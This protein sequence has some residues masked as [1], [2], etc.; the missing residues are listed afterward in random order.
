MQ[1]PVLF[2]TIKIDN[3]KINYLDYHQKR[4]T[5]SR[6]ALFQSTDILDLSSIIVA[7]KMGIWRCRIYYAKSFISVE[8]IPYTPKKIQRLKI[9]PSSLT[10]D[11]KYANREA[12][13]A[14]LLSHPDVDDVLIEKEG[15]ISDTSIANIAFYDG[16]QWVTPKH[17]LLE[18]TTR[19]RLLETGFLQTKIIKKESLSLY[20]QVALMNSMIGF[21]PLKHITMIDTQ[22]ENYDY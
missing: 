20:T 9:V 10:Y 8:Y 14:L 17:P 3:G 18:G 22:G 1:T 15:V 16:E 6:Q 19:A 7:P 21:L 12:L 11:Y 2:E 4:C 13:N 5:K